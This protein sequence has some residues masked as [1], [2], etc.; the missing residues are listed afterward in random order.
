[1]KSP[2]E[3]FPPQE[4]PEL[5][6]PD[7][8]TPKKNSPDKAFDDKNET[9]NKAELGKEISAD[10][11]NSLDFQMDIEDQ[12]VEDF[13]KTPSNNLRESLLS[14]RKSG[15]ESLKNISSKVV[16]I[17]N[18]NKLVVTL[19]DIYL[20][21]RSSRIYKELS[22][23]NK[24]AKAED[25]DSFLRSIQSDFWGSSTKAEGAF[26]K[27]TTALD[28]IINRFPEKT[29]EVMEIWPKL[30]NLGFNHFTY[31]DLFN[32]HIFAIKY[33]KF[34]V[35]RNIK[36]EMEDT[37][38]CNDF[39]A[40]A[41]LSDKAWS[42][43]TIDEII[44]HFDSII[45]KYPNTKRLPSKFAKLIYQI[46][47]KRPDEIMSDSRRMDF[48]FNLWIN[49]SQDIFESSNVCRSMTPIFADRIRNCSD[50]E[51]D[52]LLGVLLKSW[53]RGH[54]SENIDGKWLLEL[55]PLNNDHIKLIEKQKNISIDPA[56]SLNKD[57]FLGKN[58][59]EGEYKL[60]LEFA[61]DSGRHDNA[62][63][64]SNLISNYPNQHL[65]VGENELENILNALLKNNKEILGIDLLHSLTEL[66][67][68]HHWPDNLRKKIYSA[69][70]LNGETLNRI[71]NDSDDKSFD[72]IR[73]NA[74]LVGQLQ[75]DF[76]KK[77]Q[78]ND[79]RHYFYSVL[80]GKLKSDNLDDLIKSYGK[81]G[82]FDFGEIK[83]L[84]L[85]NRIDR[86]YIKYFVNGIY[87]IEYTSELNTAIPNQD[88]R[89]WFLESVTKYSKAT[90]AIYALKKIIEEIDT[91]TPEKRRELIDSLSDNILFRIDNHDTS[92]QNSIEDVSGF[93]LDK[94][95]TSFLNKEET[96]YLGKKIMN[97]VLSFDSNDKITSLIL[98][99]PNRINYFFPEDGE[100]KEYLTKILDKLV[101]DTTNNEYRTL[102]FSYFRNPEIFSVLD[103]AYRV[104]L[105]NKIF[106]LSLLD[107]GCDLLSSSS[108]MNGS[109][110][111]RFMEYFENNYSVAQANTGDIISLCRVLSSERN[112]FQ[113]QEIYTRVY[114][115]L[116]NDQNLGSDEADILL[117]EEIIFSDN[118][119]KEAFFSNL[120][121]WPKING[122]KILEFEADHQK[123][124]EKKDGQL[125]FSLSFEEVKKISSAVMDNRGLSPRFWKGYLASDEKNPT[126]YLD[127]E[128][129][130]NGIN[131]IGYD[132]FSEEG[133]DIVEF[134]E[135]LSES[136]F[137]FEA[138]DAKII[139]EK[140]F[141]KSR[142][143]ER[144]EAFYKYNPAVM[145]NILA[146]EKCYNEALGADIN[147]SSE[148]NDKILDYVLNYSFSGNQLDI[149]LNYLK[150]NNNLEMVVKTKNA[151]LSLNDAK[152]VIAQLCLLK[153]DLLDV[154]ESKKLYDDATSSSSDNARTQILHSIN[155]IGSMLSN[156]NNV[157]QLENFLDKPGQGDIENLKGISD[158]IE[159]YSQE[160]KGRSIVVMLFAREYLPDR[161]LEEVIARV[162]HSLRKYGEVIDSN[163][164]KN[165]P[166]GFRASIGME[167]EITSSTAK[168]YE[169]LTSQASLKSDIALVSEAARIGS[170]N[171]AVH[172]IAT[173]PTDNPYLMLLE[174]KLL[175]DIEYIDL[176]FDRS[177][178]YQ[179]GA[180]GFHLTIGGEKGLS[181]N[182][183]T[184]FL[185]NT[186]IAASWGGVQSGEAGHEANGGRGVSL[187]NREAD[188]NHNVNFFGNK[189]NSVELRSLSIDKQETLQRAVT[190]AFNGAIAIQAF[191]ECFP[192]G[193]VKALNLL[194]SE[195]GKKRMEEELNSKDKK[196]SDLA[197][198]W[199]EL[200]EQVDA[201]IQR[202]N[203]SFIDEEMYGYLDDKGIWVDAADFGGEYNRKRFESIIEN[204]DPTLS[205]AE[206]VKTTEIDGGEIFR[207]FNVQLSDKLTKINNLY[208]KPGTT[209]LDGEKRSNVFK[210]DNANAISMLETTKLGNLE[211]EY[212]DESFLDKT[213]F[214]A[215]G[216]KR[217]G[218]YNLQGAS[219]LM[220]THA[221]QRALIDFNLKVEKMVN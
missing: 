121:R 146:E 81:T 52:E 218:Y 167:Y 135:S 151:L 115:K 152:R 50:K 64:L 73:N 132:C 129:F 149:F 113:N 111:N 124:S 120:K 2:I 187:R 45:L 25:Y 178:D 34:G 139:I 133:R 119:I 85:D 195:G 27:V 42:S 56:L 102:I 166:E 14:L 205:L 21:K 212:Y 39:V 63:F 6:A 148:F 61:D 67:S 72:W 163:S 188:G 26:S 219:E 20:E 192:G 97:G 153:Y 17:F 49:S 55:L 172:E 206:Y 94:D 158:F 29:Q 147:Y 214:D 44:K 182:P 104:S 141:N 194:E 198:S 169:K 41:Y 112:F 59:G 40:L 173:R 165:I 143:V 23:Q 215:A 162:A 86:K 211:L 93:V 200:I 159:K 91:K 203:K 15:E 202:H 99:Y 31:D 19:R 168:G 207:S 60:L 117:K 24:L 35:P 190:T 131:N 128:I 36:D 138:E 142:K 154:K 136:K 12:I 43:E 189:S 156:R 89:I 8:L 84:F 210:G 217:K 88:D 80:N 38:S 77:A 179:K 78:E 116:L 177:E 174:M 107:K 197:R 175:H 130:R 122:T 110:R 105:E 171:D 5:Q 18:S 209:S 10:Y 32:D 48:V 74:I 125:N 193:S 4:N 87:G 71:L 83:Y 11:L 103:D 53:N 123:E 221:V 114:I 70:S 127:E 9:I 101:D 204:I 199:I 150:K 47:S 160:N 196:I 58:I 92:E 46:Y 57:K 28:S 216:E 170:G 82:S 184:N 181:A 1:M 108:T 33:E 208:L 66:M 7:S 161:P 75:L 68:R 51:T 90:E 106:S 22:V 180:R 191:K 54:H 118:K 186:I 62:V 183:E 144:L 69:N 13:S 3:I 16:N 109:Q 79:L 98:N 176:N 201:S 100:K 76:H 220:L 134:L 157:G 213:V 30:F 65:G 164:Y 95:S 37:K 126:F 140:A 155:I 185:Q 145:E 96:S 137:R